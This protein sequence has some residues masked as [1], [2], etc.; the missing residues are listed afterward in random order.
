MGFL[1]IGRKETP[2]AGQLETKIRTGC[3]DDEPNA[4]QERKLAV[5]GQLRVMPRQPSGGLEATSKKVKL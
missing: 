5:I 3:F 2:S 1:P 4:E